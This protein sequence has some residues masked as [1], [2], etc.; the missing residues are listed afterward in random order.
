MR[1]ALRIGKLRK[2]LRNGPQFLFFKL[3]GVK[4]GSDPLRG[5]DG[6]CE[7]V[8]QIDHCDQGEQYL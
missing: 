5:S 8:D 4:Y 2:I 3:F 7:R 6:F 1:P